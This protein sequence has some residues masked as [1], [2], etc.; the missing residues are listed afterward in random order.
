MT[1][2]VFADYYAS[3]GLSPTG[4]IILVREAA[5]KRVVEEINKAQVLQLTEL[6]Y[7]AEG[8]DLSWFREEYA[9]EDASFSLQSN[10]REARV[11]AGAV[12]D[13]LVDD[14]YSVALLSIVAGHVVNHR[15]PTEGKALPHKAAEA[16][17]AACVEQR[18][19]KSV[20]TKVIPTAI[21]KF[22]EEIAGITASDWPSLLA[23]LT[24]IRSEAAS[25]QKTTAGQASNALGE[26][27]RQL[28]LMREE[29]QMLWWIFGGHSRSLQRSFSQLNFSQAAISS[30]IDLGALTTVSPLGPVAAPAMLERLIA[31]AKKPKSATNKALSS[32]IDGMEREDLNRFDLTAPAKV[33]ERIA[34]VTTAIGLARTIGL[35]SWHSRFKDVTGLDASIEFDSVDLATQLYREHL[36]GQLL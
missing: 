33:P 1:K 12:L 19:P 7:G 34:P 13:Q 25:S 35:G 30:A 10:A 11:L 23:I 3:E 16:L 22:A 24:K 2:H 6:Y 32:A 17:A 36:L 8:L 20:D 18:A 28:K 9:K 4:E 31:L 14:E 15:K 27:N 26:L 5:T 21:P 29:S